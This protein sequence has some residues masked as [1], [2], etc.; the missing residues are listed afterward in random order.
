MDTLT[1]ADDI[2][3]LKEKYIKKGKKHPHGKMENEHLKDGNWVGLVPKYKPEYVQLAFKFALLGSTIKQL[4]EMFDVTEDCVNKWRHAHPE[5]GQAVLDGRDIADAEIANSLYHR[6]LGVKIKEEKAHVV[7]GEV[8]V[9]SL[10]K[11]IPADV[12]A[13]KYWLSNRSKKKWANS[14]DVDVNVHVYKPQ[15]KRFDGSED[16][17]DENDD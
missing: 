11:E 3:T 13:Q 7:E 6:A 9:T 14:G 10:E 15:I 4:A 5:F 17:E 12:G 8:I 2:K 1:M 16:S